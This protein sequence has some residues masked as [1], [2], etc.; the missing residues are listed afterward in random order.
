MDAGEQHH[1]QTVFIFEIVPVVFLYALLVFEAR[2][3][4]LVLGINSRGI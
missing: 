2:D 3:M 1:P 4:D